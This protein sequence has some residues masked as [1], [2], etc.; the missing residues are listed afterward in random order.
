M[1]PSAHFVPVVGLLAGP[2]ED[3]ASV[4]VVLVHMRAT[5][6]S[7]RRI[8]PMNVVVSLARRAL[9]EF[10]VRPLGAWPVGFRNCRSQPLSFV[11]CL[12]S[13]MPRGGIL[14]SSVSVFLGI[15]GHLCV[16]S[17]SGRPV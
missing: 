2:F 11:L 10:I 6:V 4:P 15:S 17:I 5:P 3:W 12:G 13:V 1:S 14:L 16:V 8:A 7:A 9:Q